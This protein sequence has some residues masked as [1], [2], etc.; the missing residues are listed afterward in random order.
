M[1]TRLRISQLHYLNFRMKKKRNTMYGLIVVKI[2]YCDLQWQ[3][4]EH[5]CLQNKLI[6]YKMI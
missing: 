5:S 3:L 2:I 1:K 6:K 4:N